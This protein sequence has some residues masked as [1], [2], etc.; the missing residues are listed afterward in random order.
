MTPMEPIPETVEAVDELDPSSH[1][2][3][4]LAS[5]TQLANRAKEDVPD[6]VGVSVAMLEQGIT[7]TLVAST[8]EIAVLDA[9]Q[10]AAGGPCVNGAYTG[11]RH[12][13]D[14]PTALDEGRW[15]LFAEATAARTVRSTLTLPVVKDGRVE[16]T[17]NLYA[18]TRHA[19]GGHHDELADIFGAWA[20]GAV[21][22]A[23]LSFATRG[24]ARAAPQRVRDRNLIDVAVAILAAE[25]KADEGAAADRL[26]DAAERAGVTAAQ[27]A[28]E[29][30]DARTRRD[31]EEH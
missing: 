9:V 20:A 17:V 18:A 28:R 6:L 27:L 19:F 11:E 25:L 31:R 3:D 4:L 8:D 29:I 30:V 12:E 22:N 21:A 10:Y 14:V 13:F 1:S 16:G 5:L 15:Q 24:E 2:P 23:D 26:R 7:L